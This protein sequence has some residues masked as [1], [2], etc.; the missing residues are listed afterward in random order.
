MNTLPPFL[1]FIYLLMLS[2]FMANRFAD[3]Y[4]KNEELS[5]RL[6][7]VDQLKDDFLAIWLSIRSQINQYD[8]KNKVEDGC[9]DSA[10]RCN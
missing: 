3:T 10:R 9:G 6:L 5:T 7:R 1:P 4:R 8:M 2:L